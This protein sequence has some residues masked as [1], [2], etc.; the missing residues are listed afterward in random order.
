M[1]IVVLKEINTIL[2]PICEYCKGHK[3]SQQQLGDLYV[4]IAI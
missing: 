4:G 2:K 1:S 3:K